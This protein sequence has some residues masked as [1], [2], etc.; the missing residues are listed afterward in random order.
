MVKIR[1]SLSE[2][3]DIFS[4][5]GAGGSMLPPPPPFL[6]PAPMPSPQPAP[7]Q[8]GGP[9]PA[10][11]IPMPMD[12]NMRLQQKKQILEQFKKLLLQ[13]WRSILS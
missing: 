6:Q 8:A 11:P 3:I 1:K 10:P 5:L 7:P 2:A 9:Q 13:K 4:K 12:P